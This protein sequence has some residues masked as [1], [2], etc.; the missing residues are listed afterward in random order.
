ME[1]TF[2]QK[3]QLGAEDETNHRRKRERREGAEL[4]TAI[5]AYEDKN[6][7]AKHSHIM[8]NELEDGSSTFYA[9]QSTRTKAV[10]AKW[11][12]LQGD[13]L[14]DLDRIKCLLSHD[15]RN[16][17]ELL[18]DIFGG[19]I[20]SGK[21]HPLIFESS[22]EA[23]GDAVRL[24]SLP[25][26]EELVADRR[27]SVYLSL[28]VEMKRIIGVGVRDLF[29]ASWHGYL[30]DRETHVL[31]EIVKVLDESVACTRSMA[32]RFRSTQLLI[33]RF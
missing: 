24:R 19:T 20:M 13:G 28:N 15:E 7:S 11:C 29:L 5:R 32:C 10:C 6:E 31:N 4:S 14:Y 26:F 21:V 16:D 30:N 12:H 22:T 25:F 33:S 23:D 17:P 9:N 1:A 2:D 8:L 27:Q 3:R 18:R